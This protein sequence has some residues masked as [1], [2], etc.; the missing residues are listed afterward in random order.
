VF[1]PRDPESG[2]PIPRPERGV[3]DLDRNEGV[4]ATLARVDQAKREAKIT[5]RWARDRA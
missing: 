5:G 4:D 1:W 3:T 2:H